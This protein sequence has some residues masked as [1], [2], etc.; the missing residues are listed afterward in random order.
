MKI[1]VLD[2]PALVEEL[3]REHSVVTAGRWESRYQIQRPELHPSLSATVA[4]CR[5]RFFD[6]DVLLFIEGGVKH[7]WSEMD[8][9]GK[10]LAYYAI[11]S[12]LHLSW[13]RNYA[14]LFD[15]LFVAQKDFV[16]V[17]Q[18]WGARSAHWMPLACTSSRDRNLN[19][20]RE[21]DVCF[22]GKLDPRIHPERAAFMEALKGKLGPSIR[23]EVTSGEYAEL[24][25]RS[26]IILNE[27]VNRDLNQ[28]TF[29]A[30]AC[31]GM[32]LTEEL[33]NGQTDLFVP[34]GDFVTYRHGDADQAAERIRYYLDHEEERRSIA[35]SGC[36]KV[37]ENHTSDHRAREIAALLAEAS[38]RH[39]QRDWAAD[40]F[41]HL[42]K[43]YLML[44]YPDS[45]VF[46]ERVEMATALFLRAIEQGRLDGIEPYLA[47]VSV[48]KRNPETALVYLTEALRRPSDRVVASWILALLLSGRDPHRSEACY[49]RAIQDLMNGARLSSEQVECFQMASVVLKDRLR[50]AV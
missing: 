49:Q 28:R 47:L 32:L 5:D 23:F 9:V 40:D 43:T 30:M 11:D 10:P 1:L 35:A 2:N 7:L 26:K 44:A 29:E 22:V 42:G 12:H 27:S 25:N 33:A 24:Y 6:P 39:T 19:L 21:T 15:V 46:S 31:G 34:G 18:Q 17:F 16:P 48:M 3:R 37:V 13:Q 20:E 41:F 45:P 8:R 14:R 50:S 38:A 4:E 36:R